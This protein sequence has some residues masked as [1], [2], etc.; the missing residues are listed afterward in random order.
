MF[1]RKKEVAKGTDP[2]PQQ[3]TRFTSVFFIG[4]SALGFNSWDV[5]EIGPVT[6]RRRCSTSG[7]CFADVE[8]TD[9]MN[10]PN[11]RSPTTSLGGRESAIVLVIEVDVVHHQLT[12]NLDLLS[13]ERGY[14]VEGPLGM[15]SKRGH[16]RNNAVLFERSKGR[17]TWLRVIGSCIC[18]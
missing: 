6:V 10:F 8:L 12:H 7:T 9:R 16:F 15:T 17:I 18:R 1:P 4:F 5:I 2:I 14:S 3:A 11:S 13:L